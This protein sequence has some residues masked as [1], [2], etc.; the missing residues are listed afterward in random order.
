MELE[1]IGV[2]PIDRQQANDVYPKRFGTGPS[3][4]VRDIS[5]ANRMKGALP[6]TAIANPGGE[7]KGCAPTLS[8]IEDVLR[9]NPA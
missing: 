1:K 9:E 7:K 8:R 5:I 2:L 3:A 4:A 6:G